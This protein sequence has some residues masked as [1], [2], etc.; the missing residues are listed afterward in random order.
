MLEE[1]KTIELIKPVVLGK[2]DAAQTYS[3]LK[4]REPEAG[5]IE[6][7]SRADTQIGVVITLVHLIA[8]IPRGAAEKL[9]QRDLSQCSEYLGVF[10]EA[11]QPAEP[12]AGQT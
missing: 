3:E 12:T 5:E 11:G 7:A 8:K 4:L 1:E 2:G 6:K 9:C 10:T